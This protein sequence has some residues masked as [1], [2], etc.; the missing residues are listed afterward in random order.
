MPAG[1]SGADAAAR[2][3]QGGNTAQAANA[4]GTKELYL[5]EDGVIRER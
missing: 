2:S 5:D 3:E 4:F 1:A